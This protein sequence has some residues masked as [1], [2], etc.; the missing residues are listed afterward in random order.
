MTVTLN[1]PANFSGTVVATKNIA[2]LNIGVSVDGYGNLPAVAP[3]DA[4]MTVDD[5]SFVLQNGKITY[6]YVYLWW[7]APSINN[8]F[9]QSA[10]PATSLY[11]TSGTLFGNDIASVCPA[12]CT[13]GNT[14]TT[15]LTPGSWS[16]GVLMQT[17]AA[18]VAKPQMIPQQ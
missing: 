3:G 1:V 6:W 17:P 2:S 10:D 5:A 4:N 11:L 14:E 12:P 16:D 15:N 18:S 9:I 8:P 13:I 7:Y